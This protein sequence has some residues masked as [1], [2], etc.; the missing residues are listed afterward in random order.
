MAANISQKIISLCKRRGFVYPSSEIY[1]GFAS[2]Y[3]YGPLGA[4]MLKNIRDSWWSYFVEKKKD[5]YGLEGAVFCHPKTWEAS[6]HVGSFNDPLV[7]DKVTHKRYR[8]DHLLEE[9]LGIETA[10]LSFE[11]IQ[12]L[13]KKHKIKSPEGNDLTAL[14]SF[15]LLVEA[16]LGSTEQ[17]KEKVYLRGETCQI[18]FLQY[19]NVLNSMRAKIPFGIAQ[20]GKAFRNE[21]TTKDF[22]YRTRE[23]TQMELEFF[24]DPKEGDK[25]YSYWREE[26]LNWA[27][28]ELGLA[29]GNFRYRD[30]PE[31]EK[32]HYA[33]IQKDFEFKSQSGKWFELSP[34]NH[35]ADWDLGNHQKYSGQNFKYRDPYSN[36]EF[37]PEVIEISMGLD[38]ILYSLLDNAYTED[39]Q[40]VVLKLDKRI[41]PY[42]AAVFPLLK[43]KP[44][45]VKKAQQIFHQLVTAGLSVDWDDR[46]NIG[47]RY[48]AQDEVG[49]PSC[50]TIDFQTL[51]DDTV[52][53]R[54][55][56][57]TAQIRVSTDQIEAS[58]S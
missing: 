7:E 11:E 22:I 38:R 37:L 16:E 4:Q 19:L 6:G 32:S 43:N 50:V 48:L 42:R 25:W 8:A 58:L 15:N 5:V 23:F 3:D 21:I 9:N 1:G 33:K 35:R 51:E 10:T 45:L 56:D 34:L 13:L 31:E 53:I 18:I 27:S 40:R 54:D 55:R 17:S 52:T 12:K 30:I 14:K 29:K 49:T 39:G 44:K 46:G 28:S 26:M 36:K 20:I 47:K 57:S 41:A 2:T 24:I